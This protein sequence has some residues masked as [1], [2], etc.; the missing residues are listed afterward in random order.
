M[1]HMR[2]HPSFEP[3]TPDFA[4]RVRASF[5]QQ[6]V[7]TTIGA[8]LTTVL[9]GE[10]IITLSFRQDLT[11]Q[12]GVLHAGIVTTVV[13]SACGYAAFSLMP[14]ERA[15]LTVE[16]KVNFLAPAVGTMFRAHGYVT[17]PGRTLTVCTGDVFAMR[18]HEERL[19]ATMLATMI[20]RT[21]HP[22]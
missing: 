19:I 3:R 20:M 2:P 14:P 17:K 22:A 5:A 10:V 18:D 1:M 8:T 9:P 11:Q 21:T 15:V 6:A 4:V 16:Y 7:M 12:D 13:D